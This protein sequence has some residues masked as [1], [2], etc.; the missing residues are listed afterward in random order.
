VFG[1]I[2]RGDVIEPKSQAEVETLL[3]EWFSANCG[4]EE[5]VESQI[6]EY[7]VLIWGEIEAEN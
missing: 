2:Y 6:R 7:A 1:R 3:G 5:P 4:G